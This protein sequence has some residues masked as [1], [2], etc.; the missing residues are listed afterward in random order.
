MTTT[1][2]LQPGD[3]LWRLKSG[4]K[5]WGIYLGRGEV[6][7]I[8]PRTRPHV[9]NLNDFA[10]GA[11]VNRHPSNDAERTAILA[12]AHEVL[13]S[14]F[15]YSWWR[16]NCQHLKNYVLSGRGYSEDVSLLMLALTAL[17]L[18]VVLRRGA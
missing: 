8:A 16:N 5:H 15:V 10:N 17:G 3:A 4:V 1:F 9:V 13:Q 18:A 2:N 6:L 7:Q 12:R 14:P 11:D